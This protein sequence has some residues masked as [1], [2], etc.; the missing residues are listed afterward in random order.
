MAAGKDAEDIYNFFP[1]FRTSRI[2]YGLEIIVEED[3]HRATLVWEL[4][5]L[6]SLACHIPKLSQVLEA[7]LKVNFRYL[8]RS[9]FIDIS[10]GGLI[11]HQILS[12]YQN[13][14][15]ESLNFWGAGNAQIFSRIKLIDR[16][17]SSLDQLIEKVC[18]IK[19]VSHSEHSNVK[20]VISAV[21]SGSVKSL[22]KKV[23][24]NISNLFKLLGQ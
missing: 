16:L 3:S 5:R 19:I 1:E 15:F 4:D 10:I 6:K 12:Q 8:G 7:G 14:T 23:N 11:A 24:P 9:V 13:L 18:N 2:V 22:E 17:N 21:V 20:L